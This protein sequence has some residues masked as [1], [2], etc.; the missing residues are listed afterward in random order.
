[1]RTLWASTPLS[2]PW[3][4]SRTL[5]GKI[6]EYIVM[7]RQSADGAYLVGAATDENRRTI[8]IPLDFLPKG[9]YHVEITEDGDNADYL[10]NRETTKVSHKDVTSK[11]IVTVR[12][13]PGG[14]A[15]LLITLKTK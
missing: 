4:E 7:M 3:R 15:C 9:S 2:S 10:T 14:G 8:D 11:D 13:A 5:D 1:M 6:G 12:L